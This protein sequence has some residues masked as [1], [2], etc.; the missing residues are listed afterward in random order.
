LGAELKSATIARSPRGTNRHTS[1]KVRVFC[2]GHGS[3][4]NHFKMTNRQQ[5]SA[6][7]SLLAFVLLLSTA[8]GGSAA[9]Q[10]AAGTTGGTS[11]SGDS[12]CVE[13]AITF[14]LSVDPGSTSTYCS[15][16]P[17]SCGQQDWL[18]ISSANGTNYTLDA[19]ECSV[20][21]GACQPVECSNI[22]LEPSVITSQGLEL[23]WHGSIVVSGTCGAGL[24]CL[25]SGCAPAGQY[26][27]QMCAYPELGAES[28]ATFCENAS[29][30]PTCVTVPFTW[31]PA[32]SDST[33][34]RTIGGEA[35]ASF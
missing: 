5:S 1:S 10:G 32:P 31:P 3:C 21:C 30:T 8:C 33:V 20:S 22:C 23:T 24:A 12:S 18:S 13:G 19:G 34:E 27:A 25:G 4:S 17:F 6:R 15:S 16:G 28:A 7:C 2:D 9:E 14:K 11:G 26:V 35:G 29:Q